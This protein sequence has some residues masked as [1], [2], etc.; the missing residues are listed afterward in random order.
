MIRRLLAPTLL[1]VAASN[2]TEIVVPV[3]T[4]PPGV[5]EP[6]TFALAGVGLTLLGFTRRV[7][8]KM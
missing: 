2:L 6:T 8:R 5:P 4:A 7:E 1:S 3:P